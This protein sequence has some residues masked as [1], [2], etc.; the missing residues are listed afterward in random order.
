MTY[1]TYKIIF[2]PKITAATTLQIN[3]IYNIFFKIE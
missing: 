1:K 2:F 3:K